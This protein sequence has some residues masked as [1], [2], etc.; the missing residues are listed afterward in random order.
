MQNRI[1]RLESLVLSLMTNGPQSAGPAAA[2]AVLAGT[3]PVAPL[4][5]SS[6]SGS[7]S[8]FPL[9]ADNEMARDEPEGAQAEDEGSEVEQVTKSI[10]VMKVDNNKA[11]YIPEAHWYSILAEISEVKNWF[12]D[13]KKQYDEQY[14]RIKSETSDE[15][16]GAGY[17]FVVE[18]PTS[19]AA[20]LREFPPKATCDTLISRFFNADSYD[21]AFRK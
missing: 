6:I 14:K 4:T 1:D 15:R 12:S 7:A 9:D 2:N 3:A 8:S 18:R 20:I 11:F 19:K 16:V 10:G 13:H 21:P 5:G 17:L